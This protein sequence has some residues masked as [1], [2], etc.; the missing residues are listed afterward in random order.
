LRVRGCDRKCDS[1]ALFGLC[2]GIEQ[3]GVKG[4]RCLEAGCELEFPAIKRM[5]ECSAC[6][7][8]KLTWDIK[9]E[10]VAGLVDEVANLGM[11]KVQPIEL[12]GVVPIVSLRDPSSYN[13][14]PL[15]IEAIVVMFED[16][17]DEE[18]CSKIQQTG[19]IHTYLNFDGKVLASSIMP[20]DIIT[21]EGAF[22]Y[23]LG[24]LDGLKF[25]GAIGWDSPVYVD[26][27][28]YDSWVNLLMGLK[29]THELADWGIPVYG[30][31]KGNVENQIRYSVETL[32]RIG[33]TSMALHASEYMMVHKEDS[34]VLQIL[35]T[36]FGYLSKLGDDQSISLTILQ[37]G[38]SNH[39][40]RYQRV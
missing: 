31:A 7:V 26:I 18:I 16:L 22:Y 34:T 13:F 24:I 23:Y 12:P 37:R 29:L 9:G 11:V 20:D 10:E 39:S 38:K 27:P 1:C 4:Y 17:F 2:G 6:G 3:Y 15:K 5:Q 14:D 30:L 40:G 33:I 21:Q 32:S 25:D 35:Y 28:L 36:Y 8:G 19:D